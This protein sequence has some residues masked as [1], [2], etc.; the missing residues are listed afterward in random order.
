VDLPGYGEVIHDIEVV[1]RVALVGS[2]RTAM[3]G[4]PVPE[5]LATLLDADG[6][7]IGSAITGSGGE[8]IFDDLQAG[9]YTVVASGY[10]PVATDVQVR[11]GAPTEAVITLGHPK[12]VD[13]ATGDGAVDSS[14]QREADPRG[15]T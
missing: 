11:M 13:A 15:H 6:H 12:S 1:A 7:V 2:V 8:F 4:A 5:A 10:P 3:A 9:T 14:V